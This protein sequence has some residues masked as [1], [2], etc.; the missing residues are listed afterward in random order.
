M[1]DEDGPA[2]ST[3]EFVD[4]CRTQ[5]RF[6]AGSIQTMGDEAD[7]LL[8]EVDEEVADIRTQLDQED[9]SVDHTASPESTA[10]PEEPDETEVDVA[11]I[12]ERESSLETKQAEIE[13]KQ[14]RM[15][16]YQE[17]A[18]GY[19]ALAEELGA[20][21]EDGQAA[22]TRVVEFEAENDAPAYFEE[23][24]VLEAAKKSAESGS[25]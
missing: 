15:A 8:D 2:L 24:T 20:E 16:A 3:D 9:G 6:L 7:E 22:M 25:Q 12:E 18:D 1:N 23:Q 19:T 11:A 13:A 10:G 21:V 17:L 4:Y 14:A 5:A